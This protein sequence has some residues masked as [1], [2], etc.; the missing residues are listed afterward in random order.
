MINAW[1]E[2]LYVELERVAMTTSE[3]L[4]TIERGVGPFPWT[5]GVA[6]VNKA[7][8]PDWLQ[9]HA[10]SMVDDPVA[11][12][13]STDHTLLAALCDTKAVVRAWLVAAIAQFLDKLVQMIFAAK[14]K[15]GYVR[16]ATF[17][18]PGPPVGLEQVLET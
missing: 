4:S 8:L 16:T 6:V 17:P 12:W 10:Q 15:R 14:L 7:R 3:V 2:L 1:K 5:A 11:E 13:G 9:Q 18:T